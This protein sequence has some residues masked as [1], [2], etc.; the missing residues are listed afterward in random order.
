M[1]E[2]LPNVNVLALEKGGTP[3]ARRN[4]RPHRQVV[5][6]EGSAQGTGQCNNQ[7]GRE[8]GRKGAGRG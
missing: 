5:A 6:F 3:T 8:I 7:K 4:I 2:Y 1:L